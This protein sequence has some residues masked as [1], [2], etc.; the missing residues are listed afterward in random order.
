MELN[1]KGIVIV[2]IIVKNKYGATV[3]AGGGTNTLNTVYSRVTLVMNELV[4]ILFVSIFLNPKKAIFPVRATTDRYI[5]LVGTRR[6]G[7]NFPYL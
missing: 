5:T 7:F 1:W 4:S 6:G 3:K 2:I